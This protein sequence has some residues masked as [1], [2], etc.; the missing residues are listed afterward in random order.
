ADVA[1]Q[2]DRRGEV[3]VEA[4]A[5]EHAADVAGAVELE[6]VDAILVQEIHHHVVET[7]VVL[8]SGQFE[9]ARIG[10]VAGRLAVLDA[11]LPRF[12]VAAPRRQPDARRGTVL[13]RRLAQRHEA[14]WERLAEVPAAAV[15]VPAVVEQEG[16]DLHATLDV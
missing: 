16:V 11:L 7:L 10:L 14:L 9:A 3:A 2:L 4:A 15:V 6:L 8:R 12:A 13:R 5:G 1:D